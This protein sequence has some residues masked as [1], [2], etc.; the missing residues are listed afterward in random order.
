MMGTKKALTAEGLLITDPWAPVRAHFL[1]I[2]DL[3]HTPLPPKAPLAY[4]DKFAIM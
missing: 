3:P 4:F 2:R 1:A